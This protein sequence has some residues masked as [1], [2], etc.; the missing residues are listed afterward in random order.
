M[1]SGSASTTPSASDLDT[2][3]D[4]LYSD[5]DSGLTYELS[6][7]SQTSLSS[8]GQPSADGDR[9]AG[10]TLAT[11]VTGSLPGSGSRSPNLAGLQIKTNLHSSLPGHLL[12]SAGALD[13]PIE[14]VPLAPPEPAERTATPTAD[15]SR[16]R[17]LASDEP[18]S[19]PRSARTSPTSLMP[20]R[21][22]T[23]ASFGPGQGLLA[24]GDSPGPGPP[25]HIRPAPSREPSTS[26]A[27][28]QIRHVFCQTSSSR[29]DLASIGQNTETRSVSVRCLSSFETTV[30]AAA[31]ML[32]PCR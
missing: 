4:S 17:G 31:P 32:L 8:T 15:A 16:P 23:D 14:T 6:D 21:F 9:A 20:L 27:L 18:G 10:F 25:A 26:Q 1:D 30:V 13:S 29:F 24:A 22:H 28:P 3:S 5:S 2:H 7:S 11:P 12:G 19:L